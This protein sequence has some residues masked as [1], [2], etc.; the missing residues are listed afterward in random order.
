[1]CMSESEVILM[2]SY[3]C[4]TVI[5]V[6][7]THFSQHFITI[8]MFILTVTKYFLAHKCLC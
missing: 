2:G 5:I 7:D 3:D 4:D 1:M 6:I 8:G